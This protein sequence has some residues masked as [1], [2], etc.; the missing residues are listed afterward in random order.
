MRVVLKDSEIPVACGIRSAY[1][2]NA[3]FEN[4]RLVSEPGYHWYDLGKTSLAGDSFLHFLSENDVRIVFREIR[5][6]EV[7]ASIKLSENDT[8]SIERVILVKPDD[9]VLGNISM[10]K[11]WTVFA[12]LD[13][14]DPVL[15]LETL[16][17]IPSEIQING[18]K[19]KSVTVT[20]TDG[21]F[22]FSDIAGPSMEGKTAYA[23][24]RLTAVKDMDVTLG[25]GADWWLQVWLDGKAI[26]DT[27]KFGNGPWP[28]SYKDNK[29]VVKL[30]KGSHVLAVRH[31]SGTG[32]S[33]LAVGGPDDLRK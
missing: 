28:P 12:G 26:L 1:G 8:I 25:F 18:R 20:A 9:I 5:A 17:T 30:T 13:K 32:S 22:N 31:I 10:P 16:K 21:K 27:T 24:I 29:C 15:P 23:F 19:I 11:Q 7:W 6:C 33:V 4:I 14:D 2:S 3:P